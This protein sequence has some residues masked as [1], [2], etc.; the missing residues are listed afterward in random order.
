ME[1]SDLVTI[2]QA[3]IAPFVLISGIGLILLS[4]TNRIA[5]PTDILRSLLPQLKTAPE[6]DVPSLQGQIALLRKR[7]GLLRNAITFSCLAVMG[8]AAVMI[9]L[10][11]SLLF[12]VQLTGVIKAI[13]GLSLLCLVVSLVYLMLDLRITLFSLDL[14]IERHRRQ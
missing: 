2:L 13:F 12:A 14:E 4:M 7:C 5:R 6:K 11:A 10:Y 1:T 3:S 8:V 9:L